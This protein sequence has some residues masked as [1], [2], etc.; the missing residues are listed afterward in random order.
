MNEWN[1]Q[2]QYYPAIAAS[3]QRILPEAAIN[4]LSEWDIAVLW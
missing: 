1:E 3:R 4:S 2:G